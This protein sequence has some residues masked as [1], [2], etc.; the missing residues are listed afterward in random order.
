[1]KV[2]N[3]EGTNCAY[4]PMMSVGWGRTYPDIVAQIIETHR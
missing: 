4:D 2:V 3:F 1:M